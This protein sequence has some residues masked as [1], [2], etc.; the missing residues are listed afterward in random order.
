MKQ[1]LY[2]YDIYPKVFPV[3]RAQDITVRPLSNKRTFPDGEYRVTVM[4][5]DAGTPGYEA[6]KWN[7]TDF[8]LT[9]AEDGL[10]HFSYSAASEGEYRARIYRKNGEKFDCLTRDLSF[11][12]LEDDLAARIPLRGDFHMHTCRS[13]GNEDP[14]TVCANYRRL[15]YDFIVI[16]DHGRYY[17]SLEAREIYAGVPHTLNI[18]PGEEVHMPLTDMHIV[19]AG[20]TFSVNALLGSSGHVNEVGDAIDKRS[21]DGKAPDMLKYEEYEREIRAIAG[22][23][24]CADCPE[25][26][27]RTWYAVAVWI[28][29]KI[30]EAGGLCIFAHPYWI[31]DM[32][33][34]PEPLTYYMMK[35]HP[36]DAFEVLGGENYYEQ[37]GFQT[38]LYYD[39][40]KNGRVHAIVGSTDSHGSTEH[41]RNR[42]ICSTIVF[43][44][45][46]TRE[47][48]VSAVKEKYSV[49]VDT[50]S[51]EYRLVGE[52]R[53]QKYACFLMDNWFPLHD[54]IAEMDGELML[55]YYRGD[56][57]GE[58]LALT[59]KKAE[60]LV[61][62]Y[63]VFA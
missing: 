41:N 15:G 31:A 34:I 58:E 54:R 18:L 32:Y 53:F 38:A 23:D 12:A 52:M 57:A 24:E 6:A 22:S 55:E 39:E 14:A 13:D 7:R 56:A 51:K 63:F 45:S 29:R 61:K 20:G 30:S 42:D 33:H 62:K 5:L 10:L 28:R 16:T 40:Y 37:N 44:K 48:I 8:D 46:D 35:K 36:F 4:S 21:I 50:I 17:P 59:K 11:Y 47:G 25:N 19:N 2:Y 3:R 26:V 60:A 1:H 9:P 43:A 49:A 27:D